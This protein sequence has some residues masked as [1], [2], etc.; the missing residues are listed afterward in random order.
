LK[1]KKIQLFKK[2]NGKK[3]KAQ[4]SVAVKTCALVLHLLRE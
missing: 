4:I 1:G 3:F 2:K